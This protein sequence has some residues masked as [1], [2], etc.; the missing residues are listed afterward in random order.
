GR[1]RITYYVA[2]GALPG[3]HYLECDSSCLN[4]ASWK[5]VAL[6]NTLSTNPFPRPRL[7]F[8]VSPAGSA[9]FSY[10]DGTGLQLLSCASTCGSGASWKRTMIAGT[11]IVP[12]SL[13]FGSD[14]SLQL[15]ARQRMLDQ[16]SLVFL[17]CATGCDSAASWAG[18]TGL[19]QA[20]GEIQAQ[21]ARSATG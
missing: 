13:A 21:L 8:A 1:P 16:E 4:K 7:P 10:D 17:D 2:T 18:V 14:E 9:A 20:T 15:V 19:W 11:F 5:D 6:A 3:L 12:E